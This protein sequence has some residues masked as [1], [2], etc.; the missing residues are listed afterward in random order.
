M[1]VTFKQVGALGVLALA[2]V[3]VACGGGEESTASSEPAPA[4]PAATEPAGADSAAVAGGHE[5]FKKTCAVCHGQNGEGMP[6]LGKNLNAN[7][8]VQSKSDEELLAFMIEGRPM[9]HPD[10]PRGVDY[11]PRQ[12]G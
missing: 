12:C 8:F 6:A 5:L 9:T 7:E 10:N 4:A 2:L 11:P 3:A 1:K